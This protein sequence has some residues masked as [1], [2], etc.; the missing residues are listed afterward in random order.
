MMLAGLQNRLREFDPRRLSHSTEGCRS[1]AE[2]WCDV[3][4]RPLVHRRGCMVCPDCDI[5]RFLKR[6]KDDG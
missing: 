1:M 5:I 2:Q 6:G 4:M 3:C